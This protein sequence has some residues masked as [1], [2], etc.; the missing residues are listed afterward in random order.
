MYHVV[1]VHLLAFGSID[2][3]HPQTDAIRSVAWLAEAL[4]AGER[5]L[6]SERLVNSAV[7]TARARAAAATGVG[8]VSAKELRC[9]G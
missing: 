3:R 5:W 4:S 1:R 7:A 2:T 6:E 9:P 8:K